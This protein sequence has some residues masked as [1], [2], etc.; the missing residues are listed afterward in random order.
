[1]GMHGTEIGMGQNYGINRFYTSLS[2]ME[3]EF[4]KCARQYGLKAKNLKEYLGWKEKLNTELI[5][6]IGLDRM[7][8]CNT[9]PIIEEKVELEN[10]IIREKVI[11]QTEPDVRMPMYILIPQECK[12][13]KNAKVYI[14]CAGHAG[15]GKFSVA[16][17]REIPEVADA[18]E[19]FNY[20]YGLQI[21]QKGYVVCCPDPRGFGERRERPLVAP[22]DILA[23][24]CYNVAHLAEPLGM[25]VVGMNVWDLIRLLDYIEERDEWDSDDISCL[26]FSGGGLNTLWL[27]AL[28]DRV[29]KAVISGY[30][31]GFKDSLLFL[32]NNCNCNYVPHLW[33][34][35]DAG[36]IAAMIAPR[37][38]VIQSCKDDHLNGPN[39][40]DNVYSQV[41]I[42]KEA[43]RI[44]DKEDLVMHDVCEGVHHFSSERLDEILKFGK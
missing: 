43:Y 34:Y 4:D 12:N 13:N 41:E 37:P 26:G 7:E 27:A 44:F 5:K 17:V 24:N 38:I 14:A 35:V 11:I 25:T 39:K 10:G 20:D 6:L 18:I 30:M 23:G 3:R 15:A 28:D 19:K 16:G 8:M 31:Y 33:E 1:M 36:D 32:N 40:M 2:R 29:K 9:N 22:A 21:A 42:I